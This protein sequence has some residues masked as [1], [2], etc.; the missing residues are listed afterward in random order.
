MNKTE[1]LDFWK[2]KLERKSKNL[3]EY[4]NRISKGEELGI[5]EMEKRNILVAEVS[6]IK[7]FIEDIEDL[8]AK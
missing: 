6:L 2:N 4:S 5:I 1:T 7:F 8:E 3:S